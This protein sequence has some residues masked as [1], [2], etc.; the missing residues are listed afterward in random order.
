MKKVISP[1]SFAS[2]ALAS[3][4]IA[5]THAVAPL[6]NPLAAGEHHSLFI[7]NAVNI[8]VIVPLF[9]PQNV[10]RGMGGPLFI[11]GSSTWLGN[12]PLSASTTSELLYLPRTA[13]CRY[14]VAPCSPV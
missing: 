14:V 1:A 3:C 9:T 10:V 8:P 13:D 12:S 7:A 6:G 5:P 11:D 4:V 2:I